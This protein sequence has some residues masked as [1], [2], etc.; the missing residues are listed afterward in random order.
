MSF[1]NVAFSPQD[2]ANRSK[3]NLILAQQI[4]PKKTHA[5]SYADRGQ[6][7]NEL[8]QVNYTD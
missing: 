7:E 5:R 8:K 2:A 1:C 3:F 6:F 4:H